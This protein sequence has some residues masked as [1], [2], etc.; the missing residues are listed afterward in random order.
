MFPPS[1]APPFSG[2]YELQNIASGLSLMV[3]GA[4]N[5]GPVVQSAFDG[6]DESLWTF[7]P[8]SGGYYEIQNVGSG[9][10]IDVQADSYALGA[11]VVQASPEAHG[12]GNDQWFPVAS[13]DGTY[14]FFSLSSAL[15]LDDPASSTAPGTSLDQWSGNGTT[16]QSFKLISHTP[17]DAGLDARADA[18]AGADADADAGEAAATNTSDAASGAGSDAATGAATGSAGGTATEAPRS[19]GCTCATANGKASSRAP[20]AFGV[21]ALASLVSTRRRRRA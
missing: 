21:F 12:Q 4:A 13:S 3:A 9:L 17:A 20:I 6:G 14:S 11:S 7:V 19:S 1:S 8:S 16:A 2:V 15:A 10:L 18:G 5:G